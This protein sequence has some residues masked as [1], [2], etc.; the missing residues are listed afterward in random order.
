MIKK[1]SMASSTDVSVASSVVINKRTLQI[2]EDDI[3]FRNK[4]HCID[5]LAKRW[6]YAMPEWCPVQLSY[7]S[8]LREVG[9]REVEPNKFKMEPE[10]GK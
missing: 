7:V 10:L 8:K 1:S 5:E 4:V 6:W 3:D 2:E 9:F